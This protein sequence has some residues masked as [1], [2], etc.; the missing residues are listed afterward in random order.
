MIKLQYPPAEDLADPG[1]ELLVAMRPGGVGLGHLDPGT[2]AGARNPWSGSRWRRGVVKR[3]DL[4]S[5]G[6]AA[7]YL[8]AGEC[9]V[10]DAARGAD[11]LD[12]EALLEALGTVPQPLPSPQDDGHQPDVHVVDQV[13]GQELAD[14]GRAAAD[15]DVEAARGLAGGCQ[16]FG[17]AGVDE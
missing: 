6:H 11:R 10:G 1:G 16:R 14:G 13:G 2:G 9:Q 3:D 17:R 8:P 5:G 4:G 12:V 7:V 15:A